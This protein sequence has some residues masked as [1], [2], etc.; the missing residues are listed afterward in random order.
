MKKDGSSIN[1]NLHIK[2]P[3]EGWAPQQGPKLSLTW[4]SPK[5]VY[6]K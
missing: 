5:E 3:V 2:D 1:P 6:S 4:T